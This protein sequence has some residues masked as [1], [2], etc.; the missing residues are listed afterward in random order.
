MFRMSNPYDQ[1]PQDQPG[2]NPYQPPP[3]Q[4]PPGQ[5]PPGQYPP[6]QYPASGSTPA[7]Y[8]QQ[9]P[10]PYGQQ[11]PAPYGQQGYGVATQ[12]H[13]QGTIIFVLGIV[14]IFV[15][16]CAPIA[17]WLGN[18]TLR[19]IT[20]SG[21][22]FSNVS[23]I[24]TGRMLGKVFTII[25]IVLIVLYIVFFIVIFGIAASQGNS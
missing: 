18:K 8:G 9:P 2:S 6:G 22:S 25:Y 7:P 24:R 13:P 3:G 4:P 19:E 10:A 5:P 1:N 16:V 11:P 20:A 15:G 12:E 21:A 23:Q 14:G 17:W